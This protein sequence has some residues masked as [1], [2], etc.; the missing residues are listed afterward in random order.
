MIPLKRCSPP[1]P[2][3]TEINN[4]R[5]DI[6][7]SIAPPKDTTIHHDNDLQVFAANTD[8]TPIPAPRSSRH[9]ASGVTPERTRFSRVSR[10]LDLTDIGFNV[11]GARKAG[12]NGTYDE[13]RKGSLNEGALPEE[14]KQDELYHVD[15]VDPEWMAV[16]KRYGTVYLLLLL[17]TYPT[18]MQGR[19]SVPSSSIFSSLGHL[20]PP[21]P[22]CSC[23]PSSC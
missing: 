18:R 5:L 10:S 19:G 12:I 6:P 20:S 8:R 22:S 4:D 21:N 13:K 1:T 11:A 2:S 9:N 17:L 23:R 3:S 14:I 7:V 15:S 16:A